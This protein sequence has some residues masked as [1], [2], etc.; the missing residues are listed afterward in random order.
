M[1]FRITLASLAITAGALAGTSLAVTAP[2]ASAAT[3]QTTHTYTHTTTSRGTQA[4][5]WKTRTACGRA[6][7]LWTHKISRSYTGS[8]YD[9]HVYKDERAYPHYRQVTDKYS[10]SAKG[11]ETHTVTVKTG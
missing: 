3:C 8:H 4:W 5:T 9:E 2:A 1:R 7:R 6:Y 11:V 10:W